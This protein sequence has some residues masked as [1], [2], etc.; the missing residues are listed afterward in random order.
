MSENEQRKAEEEAGASGSQWTDQE[1]PPFKQESADESSVK[2]AD[3][4]REH[5]D[6]LK[7]FVAGLVE[8]RGGADKVS[9][10]AT[11]DAEQRTHVDAHG[12]PRDWAHLTHF[13][14]ENPDQ[15]DRFV[16]E[17]KNLEY[18]KN[19]PEDL[20]KFV[21]E[22]IRLRG[23][24]DS[25]SEGA[26][27]DTEQV[28]H[29]DKDGTPRDWA[30]LTGY[31][32][33]N[34]DQLGR[35]V[36]EYMDLKEVEDAAAAAEEELAAAEGGTAEDAGAAEEAPV[37]EKP[38]EEEPKSEDEQMAERLRNDD[39]ELKR[40]CTE[41]NG[42]ELDPEEFQYYKDHP[43]KIPQLVEKYNKMKAQPE[44]TEDEKKYDEWVEKTADRPKE[45]RVDDEMSQTD[46]I[47]GPIDEEA[48]HPKFDDESEEMY[49]KRLEWEQQAR[50]LIRKFPLFRPVK[51]RDG[52]PEGAN[53]ADYDAYKE[54]H[55]DGSDETYDQWLKRVGLPTLAEYLASDNKTE[56]P[57]AAEGGKTRWSTMTEEEKKKL[58]KENPRLP[59]EKTDEWAK[60]LGIKEIVGDSETEDNKEKELSREQ[61]IAAFNLK[62]AAEWLKKRYNMSKNELEKMSDEDLK[63]LYDEYAGTKKE[64]ED[65]K[66]KELSREQMIAVFDGKDAAEW[67]KSRYN[68]S[69]ND[70]EKMSDEDLKKLYAEYLAGKKE[71]AEDKEK[72]LNREQMIAV[73]D[74]KDAAE[75][76]KGRYNMSKNELE[77]MSDEDLKKLYDEYMNRNKKKPEGGAS[78]GG[79]QE[80]ED[81]LVVARIDRTKDARAAAHDIAERMLSEKLQNG[82]GVKGFVQ[83]VILG[84]LFREGTILR[85][86]HRAYEMIKA[87]QSGEDVDGLKDNDWAVKS[88]L[89]RFVTAY[90]GGFEDEMIHGKAGESMDVYRVEKDENGNEI[91]VR[92]QPGED[93]KRNREVVTD[94]PM[95]DATIQMR[96]AISKFAQTGDRKAFEQELGDIQEEL[97]QNGGDADKLM[98]DN[99]MAVAEAA[100]ARYEHGKGIDQ[101]MAGF[102]MINGEARSNVRT[103]AHRDALDKITNRLSNS[104]IGRVLPPEVVGTA[105]SLAVRYGRSGLR[106]ALIAGGSAIVGTA[107]APAVVPVVA[108]MATA[109][110]FAAIKE[111]NRVTGDRATQARRLTQSDKAGFEKYDDQM[112]ETQYTQYEAKKITA[113]LDKA[114]ESGDPEAIKNAL[115]M[116]DTA[117]R[118]S[119]EKRIDL[120][121]Y[122]SGDTD[123]IEDERMK[124]DVARAK[125]KAEL[126]RQGVKPA[127]LAEA[128]DEATAIFEK[129]I[130]EKDKAFRSLRRRRMA[131]QGARAAV[132]SGVM[133]I[134]SQEV[135]SLFRPDQV[136]VLENLGVKIQDNNADAQNTLMAGIIGFKG[137]GESVTERV[138]QRGVEMTQ[139]Q[140]DAMNAQPGTTVVKGEP[141]IIETT[142]EVSPAE[143][144]EAN[145][146][147]HLAG[148][149]G[150]GTK[151]SDG[152]ELKG[153][154]NAN[155][156]ANRGPWMRLKGKSWGSGVSFETKDLTTENV[157]FLVTIDGKKMLLPAVAGD[158]MGVFYPDYSSM[159]PTMETILRERMFDRIQGV[160]LPGTETDGL[161]DVYSIWGYGGSGKVPE[162][163]VATVRDSIPTYDI[164]T[165]ETRQQA[166]D[167]GVTGFI[168]LGALGRKNLTVGKRGEAPKP[169]R[170]GGEPSPDGRPS[171]IISEHYSYP[172][173][174]EGARAAEGLTNPAGYHGDEGPEP[175]PAPEGTG[176]GTDGAATETRDFVTPPAPE[177]EPSAAS[178]AETTPA[179]EPEPKPESAPATVE[180]PVGL[181]SDNLNLTFKDD[182]SI[183]AAV[184]AKTG[185]EPSD[186]E[187][188]KLRIAMT[189]WNGLSDEYRRSLLKGDMTHAY[190]MV[191]PETAKQSKLSYGDV[192]ALIYL[193]DH[194]LVNFMYE[195]EARF[196]RR[197][198]RDA[199]AAAEAPKQ[200]LKSPVRFDSESLDLPTAPSAPEVRE[201]AQAKGKTEVSYDDML[202]L[203]HA[204]GKWN[205]I[206]P[207]YRR[208]MLDGRDKVEKRG[209]FPHGRDANE[210]GDN[211]RVRDTLVEFGLIEPLPVIEVDE[212]S[213]AET[214]A[215]SADEAA[216]MG[217]A[218]EEDDDWA[219]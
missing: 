178:A 71:K 97:R 211:E 28:T 74:G 54:A 128:I 166:V 195:K 115:A 66:E 112:K 120:I 70:L 91:V 169:E 95:R 196:S 202:R 171:R 12:V 45:Y 85:Y 44:K 32:K 126:K 61:M 175:G 200:E 119:D 147:A 165:E 164:I 110:V 69:K 167:R 19:H 156:D 78:E 25:V 18:F 47:D 99:Y 92:Y 152:N 168:T 163:M 33:K 48:Y 9:E 191:T 187:I 138:V 49:R 55:K 88:G 141:R 10:G 133:S 1:W 90:V 30:H 212:D 207:T 199:I 117:V 205:K 108:G 214:T 75:W 94:G 218:A 170:T 192:E 123:T 37:E 188:S 154:Y 194:G 185:D 197:Y 132:T 140:A 64:T 116:A 101:V 177:P 16:E 103:E 144:V 67:L 210:N 82:K 79:T 50:D 181:E 102:A 105:A 107:L 96:D 198:W 104:V 100:R 182:E 131:A 217:A 124:M 173:S 7:D 184:K 151:V 106:T 63:K 57:A 23:G 86:E 213:S 77:K 41:T 89:E 125:A 135:I 180:G 51:E 6:E 56:E 4:Y 38:A 146:N 11:W 193:S 65:N 59:G 150:N 137:A 84:N 34:P 153:V 208:N 118:M 122:S 203:M 14:R 3:Y 93:G 76:L 87:K 29:T 46:N 81:P 80:V 83:K 27:W 162:T 43:D 143:Y 31:L 179:P 160:Y 172:T 201:L 109:G 204:I 159:D 139:E 21:A 5:P 2:D 148:Y 136:G 26:T 157:G 52:Y 145:E 17:Y 186:D 15:I 206:D 142:K 189:R 113:N 111:R 39:E 68:M 149:L 40:I 174:M 190:A 36:N 24:A 183:R 219:A 60:R 161:P 58:I 216:K 209:I 42:G 73:F 8:L 62:D 20:S 121:R 13:L 98:A 129:D 155:H 134:A 176:D 130:S 158:K 114:L 53:H 127:A 22:L 72:E 35:F 215:P